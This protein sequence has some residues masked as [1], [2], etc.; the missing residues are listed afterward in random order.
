MDK[1]SSAFFAMAELSRPTPNMR[2]LL[3]VMLVL[4]CALSVTL[5]RRFQLTSVGCF[6]DL[7]TGGRDIN[8]LKDFRFNRFGSQSLSQ[9]TYE[10]FQSNVSVY[11]AGM[12]HELCG[13]IC[14]LGGY[15]YIGLQSGTWCYCGNSY[16][17]Q[18]MASI[19]DCYWV[20]GGNS[21]QYCGA[22]YRN[23]VLK[24]NYIARDREASSLWNI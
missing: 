18:G 20:C 16:G 12:T 1:P 5:G 13:N 21:S 7:T 23:Y 9:G 8:E 22:N 4:S 11:S 17:R 19:S 24:L 2:L 6:V 14:A 3:A 10:N 15:Q